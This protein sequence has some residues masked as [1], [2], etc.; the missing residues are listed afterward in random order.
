MIEIFYGKRKSKGHHLFIFTFSRTALRGM[1]RKN[2]RFNT[3]AI[4]KRPAGRK[5]G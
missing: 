1:K 3:K 5:P 2:Q 4:I